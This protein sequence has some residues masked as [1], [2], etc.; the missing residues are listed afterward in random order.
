METERIK[1]L[2]MLSK[3]LSSF[4]QDLYWAYGS[5]PKEVM[6]IRL[7]EHLRLVETR[8]EQNLDKLDPEGKVSL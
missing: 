2:L 4:H 7:K 6:V 1:D 3:V 5:H 8:L